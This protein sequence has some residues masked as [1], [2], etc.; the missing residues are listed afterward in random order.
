MKE[1]IEYD[2]QLY[3][4]KIENKGDE[5][6]RALGVWMEVNY[7]RWPDERIDFEVIEKNL[8]HICF[9]NDEAELEK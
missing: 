2:D 8:K 6:E 3:L 5:V 4:I 1:L 9:L 7:D